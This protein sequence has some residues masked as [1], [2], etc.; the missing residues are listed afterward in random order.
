MATAFILGAG[1]SK[2]AGLPV[3]SEFSNLL[4][5]Q[6]FSSPLDVAITG[7]LTRFLQDVFAWR[8]G[9]KIP[10]LEDIFTCI[11]LS[12]NSG[13]HLGIEH[14][15]KVLRAIRRMTI[16]RI[17]SILDYR[18]DYSPEIERLLRFF[19]S[20]QMAPPGFIVLNWDIV[21]E[22]HLAR[23]GLGVDYGCDT[24][25]WATPSPIPHTA[26]VP[27]CKMHGSSNW[28]YCEN[29]KGLFYDL[30]EKL[31]LRSKVGLI[32]HDFRLFD[33]KFSGKHFNRLLNLSPEGRRCHRCKNMVSSHIATF[34]YRKSFRT[35]A[36]PAIWHRAEDL[37]ASADHWIF[38]G[39][40][41][42]K[43][44]YE[45]KSLLKTAQLRYRHLAARPSKSIDVVVK[46]DE[47]KADYGAFFGRDSFEYFGHGLE[48]YVARLDARRERA[49][50]FPGAM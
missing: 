24:I 50:T 48:E 32:K 2:C 42:P 21:L 45:L 41:L 47:A 15:P 28:V 31:A 34:S 27:V 49:T 10:E 36:Y 22:K 4:L 33:E 44:D 9:S 17:F 19:T 8:A 43:A 30:N 35:H 46:G 12:A 39:Y 37:L 23:L 14:T 16:H 3:Q 26:P 20:S 38:I 13:H 6:I 29:C 25:D 11:D 40:S 5:N 1:F 18:F 7:V